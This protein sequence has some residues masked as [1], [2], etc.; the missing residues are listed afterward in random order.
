MVR[1]PFTVQSV[2]QSRRR[3]TAYDSLEC[4]SLQDRIA[5]GFDTGSAQS[6]EM[7][8]QGHDGDFAT[9]MSADRD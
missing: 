6:G 5:L 1:F 2:A 7:M 3:Q 8:M 9:G 4:L